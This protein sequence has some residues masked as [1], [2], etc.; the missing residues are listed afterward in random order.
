MLI[1]GLTEEVRWRTSGL[2]LGPWWRTGAR[3]A[4][5]VG[6]IRAVMARDQ[7]DELWSGRAE[8]SRGLAELAPPLDAPVVGEGRRRQ[9]R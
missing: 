1:R 7:D 9:E 4:P 6:R 8:S 5:V 3:R 2:L